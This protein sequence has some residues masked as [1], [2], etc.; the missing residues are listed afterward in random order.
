[1]RFTLEELRLV[2]LSL[3]RN[4]I[5]PHEVLSLVIVHSSFAFMCDFRN[6]TCALFTGRTD[7]DLVNR[8]VKA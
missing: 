3:D 4:P 1:M 8:S 2:L 7:G 6:L 5:I